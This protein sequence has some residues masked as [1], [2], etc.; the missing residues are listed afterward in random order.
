MLEPI[1][2]LI[3]AAA[4]LVFTHVT[5]IDATGSPAQP[6]MTVV[7]TGDRITAVGKSADVRADPKAQVIDGKGK[8][9]IPGLW[10]MHGHLTDAGES[11]FSQLVMNVVMLLVAIP[12]VLTREPGRLKRSIL[13]CLILVGLCIAGYFISFQI[14]DRPPD[15]P[16]WVDRWPAMM[17]FAPVLVF[18]VLAVYLLD[19]LANKDT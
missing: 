9:L 14:A 11:S 12:C 7:V 18:G 15:G 1:H 16:Q 10:D 4:P 5:V 6:D 3:L 19:R 13:K 8:F 17:A 2:A